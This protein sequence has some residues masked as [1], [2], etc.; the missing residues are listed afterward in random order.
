[1]QLSMRTNYNEGFIPKILSI[2]KEKIGKAKYIS[3]AEKTTLSLLIAVGKILSVRKIDFSDLDLHRMTIKSLEKRFKVLI[4]EIDGIV[5]KKIGTD[6]NGYQIEQEADDIII[7]TSSFALKG[8]VIS[9]E[10][11]AL[12]LLYIYFCEDDRGLST[13]K[14]YNLLKDVSFYMWIFERLEKS[15]LVDDFTHSRIAYD[16]L[17]KKQLIRESSNHSIAKKGVSY[18]EK[19]K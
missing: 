3:R 15:Q 9:V 17:I 7:T 18:L 11:I 13:T 14:D 6:S 16:T 1:M 19:L 5:F 12:H 8:D 2:P 10:F 4:Q